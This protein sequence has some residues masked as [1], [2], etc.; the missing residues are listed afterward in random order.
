[1][2][3]ALYLILTFTNPNGATS[4]EWHGLDAHLT[5]EQCESYAS[6]YAEFAQTLPNGL[7]IA[8]RAVCEPITPLPPID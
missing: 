1:M 5:R 8:Q 3:Y 2:P 7:T 4:E 6:T